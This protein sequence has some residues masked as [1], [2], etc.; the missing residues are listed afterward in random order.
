LTCKGCDSAQGPI[1]SLLPS[2][3]SALKHFNITISPHGASI[4]SPR[5]YLRQGDMRG[6]HGYRSKG[7][8]G[9]SH[10]TIFLGINFGFSCTYPTPFPGRCA[11]WRHARPVMLAS[12]GHS[13]FSPKTAPCGLMPRR[14]TLR[15]GILTTTTSDSLASLLRGVEVRIRMLNMSGYGTPLG[16]PRLVYLTTPSQTRGVAQDPHGQTSRVRLILRWAR[17]FL[18][19][20]SFFVYMTTFIALFEAMEWTSSR[21]TSNLTCV[22]TLHIMARRERYPVDWC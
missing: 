4:E 9:L 15:Y 17:S 10:L 16:T 12:C 18:T 19:L 8:P 22:P 21:R 1:I 13:Q 2:G 5:L 6:L 7:L 20:G 3:I 11:V 14:L